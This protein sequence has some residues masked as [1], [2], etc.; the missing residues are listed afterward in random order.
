MVV[1]SRVE[2]VVG[3]EVV[4]CVVVVGVGVVVDCAPPQDTTS[5]TAINNTVINNDDNGLHIF[6]PSELI[7]HNL[8][9]SLYITIVIPSR[10]SVNALTRRDFS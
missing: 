2:V 6:R 10:I 7:Y 1:V 3:V 4:D 9:I 5:I 8:L